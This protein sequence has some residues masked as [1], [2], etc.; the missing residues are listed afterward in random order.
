LQRPDDPKNHTIPG[1]EALDSAD[2]AIL[3]IRRITLP[4]S[5]V[6]QIRKYV[7]SGKPLIGLRTASHSFENW[8]EFDKEVLG[9]NYQNHYGNKLK[10][11]VTLAPAAQ[12]HPITKGFTSFVSDGSL[13]KNT[14]LQPAAK[15]LL[16][17]KV[18][19]F[20]AEPVA[21]THEYKGARVFYTSLGHPSDFKESAFKVLVKNAIAWTLNKPLQKQ[22]TQ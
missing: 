3:F 18:E 13:Y 14:P 8:K 4:K 2:L 22:A 6:D 20:A 9:G 7:Q 12:D 15:P 21:W 10:T 17:G 5:E 11:A 1:L 16:M 19:G